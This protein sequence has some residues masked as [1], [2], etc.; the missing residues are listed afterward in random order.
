MYPT[1]AQRAA[2]L[3]QCRHARYIWNLAVE[4]WSIGPATRAQR[5]VMPSSVGS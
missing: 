5:Q 3:E 4:Q 1:P 2:L